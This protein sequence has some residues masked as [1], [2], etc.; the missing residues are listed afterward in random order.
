MGRSISAGGSATQILAKATTSISVGD[1]IVY[2]DTFGIGEWN[3][4][5][6]LPLF[7]GSGQRLPFPSV[8]VSKTLRGSAANV[9]S[10]ALNSS[11]NGCCI[12]TN[13]NIVYTYSGASHQLRFALHK[14][15]GTVLVAPTVVF[16]AT[17]V[18]SAVAPLPGGGFVV[19]H[20]GAVS[21]PYWAIYDAAGTPVTNGTLAS[22]TVQHVAVTSLPSG[23]FIYGFVD[24][25][26]AKFRRYNSSGVAQ[27][28]LT[29]VDSA[30]SGN[31]FDLTTM[32]TG[33]ACVWASNSPNALEFARYDATGTLQ[34]SV[35]S[36]AQSAAP[37][38]PRVT[39]TADGGFALVW[40]NTT[41]N[42]PYYAVYSVAGAVVKAVTQL[43][44]LSGAASL[45]MCG[46]PTGGFVVAAQQGSRLYF[47]N[48]LWEVDSFISFSAAMGG[49]FLNEVAA[50][51]DGGI[52]LFGTDGSQ[53]ARYA[54]YS[55]FAVTVVGV[56]LS[57]AA[58]G[59]NALVE[60]FGVSPLTQ[61]FSEGGSYNHNGSSAPGN[62]GAIFNG[63]L[64]MKG[65]L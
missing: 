33:F 36:V 9:E 38:F 58:V 34:G 3:L 37:S 44:T 2:T 64:F 22:A 11:N 47:I 6:K 28:T 42:T 27:G 65:L 19:V 23:D 41:T 39:G 12:L 62:R 26:V 46:L 50:L 25:G 49:S 15:D 21:T 57:A 59:Q 30:V 10:A 8:E 13:G 60:T 55:A 40:Q 35:G 31:Y 18:R 5:P 43:T 63:S 52:V 14:P 51:V 7:T 32:G 1:L 17:G 20:D 4:P 54:R 16:A 48:N 61:T 53:N 45:R 56:A 29:T 24:S